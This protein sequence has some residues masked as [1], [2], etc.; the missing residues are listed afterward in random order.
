M[1]DSLEQFFNKVDE[2][3]GSFI[4]DR[5]ASA[6]KIQSVSDDPDKHTELDEMTNFL[7]AELEKL[8][9]AVKTYDIGD[10]PDKKAIKLPKVVVGRYPKISD[11]KKKTILVYGHYD[12]QPEGT[13]WS[14]CP[15]KLEEDNGRLFGR[16]TTDDKGPVLS[17]INAL[18]AHQQAKVDIPL[19]V[20]FCFEGMEESGSIGFSQFMKNNKELFASVDAACISDN[21]WLTTRKP[22]LTYG[23]RGIDYFTITVSHRGVQLHSG[24]FGGTVHEPLTD[25]VILL[26]KLVDSKGKILI[27]GVN[28]LVDPMTLTEKERYKKIDFQMDDFYSSIGSEAAIY[29][30]P[31]DTLM[32][33]WRYPSLTIHGISGADSSTDETTAI[34]PNV[35]AKFSIRTVPCMPGDK[36]A[37]LT[38]DYINSEFAKLGS[39]NT[40]EAALFGESVPYWMGTPDDTNF[41]AGSNATERVYGTANKP[42]LTREG[43]SIGV[44]LDLQDTLADKSIMLLPVG[45][46]NDG[47]HGPDEKID[48]RN[49][50][51]G[52]KL[53]GAYWHYFAAQA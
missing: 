40:C 2:L 6:I 21:Y 32:H 17:W 37:K 12:V 42:D 16:G 4:N 53:L 39:K 7:V 3:S 14:H 29:D 50:I 10:R 24:M 49:Y 47:A 18:D 26:S 20:L 9:V 48:K 5:L 25:L 41:T 46:S 22:C 31:T 27:P 23:L 13:G 1:P 33:R 35:T 43:G 8:D 52:A 28:E 36:V 45:T 38:I 30:N 15:W 19:N 44:T 11:S 51:D 34:Y